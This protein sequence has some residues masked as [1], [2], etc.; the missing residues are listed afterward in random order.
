MIHIKLE[1]AYSRVY[2]ENIQIY[3]LNIQCNG[4]E[5]IKNAKIMGLRGQVAF[6]YIKKLVIKDFTCMDL[7]KINFTCSREYCS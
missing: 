4:F 6:F 2:D 7:C 3:G 5:S 1:G